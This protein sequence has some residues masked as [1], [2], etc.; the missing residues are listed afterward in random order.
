MICVLYQNLEDANISSINKQL[1]FQVQT[2]LK[3]ANSLM[4][5]NANLELLENTYSLEGMGNIDVRSS[6]DVNL[7]ITHDNLLSPIDNVIELP[8]KNIYTPSLIV[9]YVKP[10]DS[11]WKISKK[12][13]TTIDNI[14]SVNVLTTDNIFPGQQLIILKAVLA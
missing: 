1:P 9:Y 12:Y 13:S 2:D 4:Q 6:Y 8:A 14:R 7:I 5:A 11:L 3:G 10:G